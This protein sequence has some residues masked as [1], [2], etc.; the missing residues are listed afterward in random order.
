MWNWIYYFKYYFLAVLTSV[1]KVNSSD[2]SLVPIVLINQVLIIS[3][4]SIILSSIAVSLKSIA[5]S[6]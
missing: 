5:F 3:V 4:I 2:K 1:S 6:L